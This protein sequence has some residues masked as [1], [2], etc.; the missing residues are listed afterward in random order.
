MHNKGLRIP[1]DKIEAIRLYKIAIEKGN[2][3][4]MYDYASILLRGIGVPVDKVEASKYF[5]MEA[6]LRKW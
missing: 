4:S 1:V 2:V 3:E 5:K 6:D